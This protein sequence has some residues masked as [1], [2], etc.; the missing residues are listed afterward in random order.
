M[1]V[2]FDTSANNCAQCPYDSIGDYPNCECSNGGY[3]EGEFCMNC[4]YNSNGTY[5]NCI[6]E[7]N[8]IFMKDSNQ[9]LNCPSDRYV[10]EKKYHPN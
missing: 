8:A 3:F 9:C 5:P 7:E 6:C 1:N 4:P 2:E 10:I